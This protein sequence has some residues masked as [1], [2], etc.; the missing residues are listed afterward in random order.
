MAFDVLR[1]TSSGLFISS[2]SSGTDP[3]DVSF[4][5]SIDYLRYEQVADLEDVLTTRS[6]RRR[7][8][9][10]PYPS[11]QH[12]EV[13]RQIY[14][15]SKRNMRWPRALAFAIE[16]RRAGYVPQLVSELRPRFVR[17]EFVATQRHS[18]QL[19]VEALRFVD[20]SGDDRALFTKA[21]LGIV[22]IWRGRTGRVDVSV[23]EL[24]TTLGVSPERLAPIVALLD[25]SRWCSIGQMNGDNH[26]DLLV[27]PGDPVLVLRNAHITTFEEYMETWGAERQDAFVSLSLRPTPDLEVP[28][29]ENTPPVPDLPFGFVKK[30]AYRRVLEA[31][32]E[33]L[34]RTVQARAWKA[35]LILIGGILEGSLL[36]VL[37]RRE[38]IS[39][40][41]LQKKMSKASL[42]DLIEPLLSSRPGRFPAQAPPQIR[43]RRFP[44]SGSSAR[45]GS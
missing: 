44:P 25:W 5:L 45:N 10:G 43:T 3:D 23:A 37:S 20:P 38:D 18:I 40:S 34:R 35:C 13:L 33:E 21:V 2:H 26:V 30:G 11:G 28:P 17:T 19:E 24:A 32:F 12:L 14:E 42:M 22:E 36:D 15:S 29:G 39:E 8:D 41:Q 1:S 6:D 4:H 9:P 31:D 27:T 7:V 16:M